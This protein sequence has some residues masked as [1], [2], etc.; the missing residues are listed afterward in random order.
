V[1]HLSKLCPAYDLD[2]P[3]AWV[4]LPSGTSPFVLLLNRGTDPEG[5]R[6]QI[7]ASFIVLEPELL[8]L[9]EKIMT[10]ANAT[11]KTQGL[12]HKVM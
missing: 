7:L 5:F 8:R 2:D 1:T 4:Q 9:E 11:L 3:V 6:N 12:A 10:K